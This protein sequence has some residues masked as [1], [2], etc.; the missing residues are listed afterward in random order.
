MDTDRLLYWYYYEGGVPI[1]DGLNPYGDWESVSYLKGITLGHYITTCS[2]LYVQTG[3]E[4]WYLD[5]VNYCVDELEK[6]QKPSGYLL[7]LPE[8]M[9]DQIEQGVTAG[10]PYYFVHKV[11]AGLLD[12]YTYCGNKKALTLASRLGDWVYTRT[13]ALTPYQ[14]TKMLTIEYGGVGESLYNLYAVTKNG[15]YLAA[16]RKFNDPKFVNA[17]SANEDNITDIHANTTIPKATALVKEYL[18]SNDVKYLAAAENFWEMVVATRTFSNGG[19]AHQE[20]FRE[21]GVLAPYCDELDDKPSETCNIYNMIK[22]SQYLYEITGNGKYI[23]YIERALLNGIMGSM[24]DRGCKTYY[25][26][27]HTN[28][29][30][31]FHGRASGFWCCT[32]T[33]MENFAKVVESI[34]HNQGDTVQY[35]IFI[36]SSYTDGAFAADMKCEDEHTLITVTAG[37]T[38]TVALRVPYWTVNPT[39]KING[40]SVAVKA[41]ENG[42]IILSRDWNVGDTIEYITPYKGSVIKL[43]DSQDTFSIM[44]GPYLMAAFGKLEDNELV[45]SYTDGWLGNLT[46]KLVRQNNGMFK[47]EAGGE[48]LTMQ[49]YGLI[50]QG[51]YTVYFKRVD[52]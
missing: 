49:K 22:L 39:L 41:D 38:K 5:K 21:V 8:T 33:G 6:C 27:L 11:M 23:D 19:N 26:Y 1:P 37:G 14:I 13:S 15:N 40:E 16:A 30:K 12:A 7:S 47:L 31:M 29:K 52:A 34:Y 25:Q 46:G 17:W 2:M 28:A 10:V 50:T 20:H 48:T 24:N 45:G 36:S 51:N 42:Y 3:G 44:Y 32:G 43:P 35:N 4:Q 9:F 18:V